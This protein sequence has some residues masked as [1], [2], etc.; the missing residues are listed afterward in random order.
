MKSYLIF[1]AVFVFVFTSCTISKRRYMDGYHVEWN[2]KHSRTLAEPP[3]AQ[4]KKPITAEI[5]SLKNGECLVEVVDTTTKKLP[6]GKAASNVEKVV[7][8]KNNTS[9]WKEAFETKSDKLSVMAHAALQLS[10]TSDYNEDG[11]LTGKKWLDIIIAIL[12]LFVLVLFAIYTSPNLGAEINAA[13]AAFTANIWLSL[14]YILLFLIF[15][16]LV[17]A[18]LDAMFGAVFPKY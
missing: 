16:A 18:A 17:W 6:I 15:V 8:K 1:L 3:S 14:L 2:H 10:D 11:G 5:D 12:L 4:L 9:I 7:L 13:W